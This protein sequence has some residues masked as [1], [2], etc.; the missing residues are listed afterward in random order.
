[1]EAWSE[2]CSRATGGHEITKS[3]ANDRLD[4]PPTDLESELL[5]LPDVVKVDHVETDWRGVSKPGSY[6]SISCTTSQ[7]SHTSVASE[8]AEI[9]EAFLGDVPAHAIRVELHREENRYSTRY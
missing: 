1:M 6:V 7:V 8:I 5:S 9:A 3:R 2:I 4:R